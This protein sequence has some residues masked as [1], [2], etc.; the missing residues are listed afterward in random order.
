MGSTTQ[1]ASNGGLVGAERELAIGNR[2]WARA[3]AIIAELENRFLQRRFTAEIYTGVRSWN[4]PQSQAR[5]GADH[6]GQ[7]RA[8]LIA[9]GD[10]G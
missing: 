8:K 2:V 6:H 9:F 3:I 4:A 10:G 1:L 7:R 5:V